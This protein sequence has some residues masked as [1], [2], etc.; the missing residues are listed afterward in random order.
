MIARARGPRTASRRARGDHA[1][2]RRKLP[3]R[4]SSRKL[5]SAEWIAAC[6]SRAK[7]TAG[8][9]GAWPRRTKAQATAPSVRSGG[10]RHSA[11]HHDRHR[12]HQRRQ[13]HR[14]HRRQTLRAERHI[15]VYRQ[16]IRVVGDHHR[17]AEFAERTQP[18][19]QQART[20]WRATRSAGSRAG[21]RDG[22]RPSVAA[23]P[24]STGSTAAKPERAAMIRNGAATKTCGSTMPANES[25]S[26]PLSSRPSGVE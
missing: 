2:S 7:P 13:Q 19:E 11:Q 6:G 18:R 20:G 21:T 25:V 14:H 17:R 9:F 26:A 5:T 4:F 12:N 3:S 24:S 16:R 23:T 8:T 15:G 10:P 22:R 1:M